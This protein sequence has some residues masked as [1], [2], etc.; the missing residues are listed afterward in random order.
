MTR[1]A[2]FAFLAALGLPCQAAAAPF[3]AAAAEALMQDSGCN[4]CHKVDKKKDGPAYRDVA[5]K[6]REKPDAEALVTHHVTSGEMVKF[7]DGHE[8]KHK[9]VK[10][11]NPADVKNLVNWILAMEGGKKY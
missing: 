1:I 4:K 7:D 11:T 9:K 5:A 2:V 3:N 6:F 8:E 10:T